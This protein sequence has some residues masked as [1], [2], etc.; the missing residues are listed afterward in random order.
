MG[1]QQ[2]M[3]AASAFTVV[4]AGAAFIAACLPRPLFRR[5]RVYDRMMI[6]ICLFAIFMAYWAFKVADTM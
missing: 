5:R 2:S 3:F 6:T 4:V 1:D